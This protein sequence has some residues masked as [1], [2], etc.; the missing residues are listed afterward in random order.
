MNKINQLIDNILPFFKKYGIFIAPLALF[1]FFM[2]LLVFSFTY[3][4]GTTKGTAP[5]QSNSPTATASNLESSPSFPRQGVVEQGEENMPLWSSSSFSE[6]DLNGTN[7]TKTTLSDGSIQYSYDSDT[8][9]RQKIIIVKNG[10]NIFQRTP[11]YNMTT[12]SASNQTPD[13]TAK[14]SSFW[15]ENAITY[16]YLS[17]GSAYVFDPNSKQIL[18]QM[19]FQPGT[20]EQFKQYDTDIIGTPQKP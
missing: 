18:E 11:L 17:A 7:Y 10:V 6:N 15:G 14:G 13:Y 3:Q 2:F 20:I 4:R 19:I 9:N 5:L 12:Q 1:L 16:I 8:P